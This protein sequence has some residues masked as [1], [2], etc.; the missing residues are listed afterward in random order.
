VK[1]LTGEENKKSG[2]IPVVEFKVFGRLRMVCGDKEIPLKLQRPPEALA[3]LACTKPPASVTEYSREL[4]AD[5]DNIR[6]T[7]NNGARHL[8]ELLRKLG[9]K[10][11]DW[12]VGEYIHCKD[13]EIPIHSNFSSDAVRFW[14]QLAEA[15]RAREREDASAEADSLCNAVSIYEEAIKAGPLLEGCEKWQ[16]VE[17]RRKGLA[18]ACEGAKKRLND[19]AEQQTDGQPARPLSRLDELIQDYSGHL[20]K[21]VGTIRLSGEAD[22]RELEKV[23]VHLTIAD[24]ARPQRDAELLGFMDE[25]TRQ[26]FSP[27]ITQKAEGGR[28]GLDAVRRTVRPDELLR[29]QRRVVITGAPGCGKTTLLRYLANETLSQPERL[30]IFLEL[31]TLSQSDFDQSLEE[32]LFEKAVVQT[33]KL[34]EE[35]RKALHDYFNQLLRDGRVTIFL[36]GLDEISYANKLCLRIAEFFRSKY[37]NNSLFISTRPYALKRQIEGL[38]EQMEIAPLNERQIGEFVNHYF[39]A[40]RQTQEFLAR[41]RRPELRE[42]ARVP[43]L[44]GFILRL[45]R[46]GEVIPDD[47]L[48]LYERIVLELVSENDEGKK[49]DREFKVLDPDHAIK[50]AFLQHLAFA[51]LFDDGV[52]DDAE[53]L[54]FSGDQLT[55]E[56]RRFCKDAE[57]N[58]SPSLLAADVKKTALLREAGP[59]RWAFT[60][61][62]L[63][64]Y[65]AARALSA[66]ALSDPRDCE[67]LFCR[68]YFNPKLAG[69]EVLPMTLGM[70]GKPDELYQ[71]V[72]RLPESLIFTGLRLRLRGLTYGAVIQQ[73]L[74]GE[75]AARL[76]EIV[77]APRI[78][79]RPYSEIIFRSLSGVSNQST[80]H[81]CQQISQLLQGEDG[82]VRQRA[83]EALGQV[84]GE[85]AVE[86]L[87]G[88]LGHQDSFVRQSAAEALGQ[89]THQILAKGL[90]KAL[91]HADSSVRRKAA[92]LIGYYSGSADEEGLSRLTTSDPD[93]DVR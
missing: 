54:I 31:K 49:L 91:S 25:M 87:V 88:A 66:R 19:L 32:P 46:R 61:L 21:Q 85:R 44:L 74:L 24:Y 4:K 51:R 50:R 10:A 75:L 80:E 33:L 63:Q 13:G 62:T 52:R 77:I 17:G 42:M 78:E 1:T 83:A 41:L 72:G 34:N 79:E 68:A 84:G 82:F 38:Q 7:V 81:L 90:Q 16:W 11:E 5:G 47:R 27:F 86:A 18:D 67:R 93:P 45:W 6:K 36:D 59:D 26:R 29:G 9:V 40:G 56:A 2:R 15:E 43:V 22:P 64:E 58:C 92:G 39:G 48:K 60:H 73:P 65:L 70:A 35:E 69:L 28:E 57:E 14:Q 12:M 37:Q 30:P 20:K 8:V 71:A 53:R 76:L 55:A 89:V 3:F 23:F